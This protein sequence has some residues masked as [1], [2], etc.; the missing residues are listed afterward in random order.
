MFQEVELLWGS[1]LSVH[2]REELM[3]WRLIC[4]FE[5]NHHNCDDKFLSTFK[6]CFRSKLTLSRRLDFSASEL[7]TYHSIIAILGRLDHHA[8]SFGYSSGGYLR[9]D[10]VKEI[11]QLVDTEKG[12]FRSTL[13]FDKN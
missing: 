13:I 4:E 1:G 3:F 12:Y 9:F 11:L 6:I 10:D 2:E 8:E 5:C 7:V